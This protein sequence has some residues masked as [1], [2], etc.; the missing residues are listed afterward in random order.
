[1][2]IISMKKSDSKAG[3]ENRINSMMKSTLQQESQH[4][5]IIAN[6]LRLQFQDQ[7]QTSSSA[8]AVPATRNNNNNNSTRFSKIPPSSSLTTDAP[9]IAGPTTGLLP[10]ILDNHSFTKAEELRVTHDAILAYDEQ[11]NSE[12]DDFMLYCSTL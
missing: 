11:L 6:I 9:I 8:A 10:S 7:Q 5:T 3:K 2:K 1:M 4:D 12:V